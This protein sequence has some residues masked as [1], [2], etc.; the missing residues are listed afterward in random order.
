[1]SLEVLDLVSSDKIPIPYSQEISKR[2]DPKKTSLFGK[3]FKNKKLGKPKTVAVIYLRNNGLAE[4][5][6]VQVKQGFFGIYGKTYHERRDCTYV[7]TKN[8][9]PLA[10]IMEDEILPIGLKSWNDKDLREKC[11]ALQEHVM[12]GI[13]HAER[14]RMGDK[15]QNNFDV[16]KIL[17]FLIVAG[18]AIAVLTSL[19]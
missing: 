9:F 12:S 7:A 16:K 2:E 18:I 3:L 4:F 14:V 10:L 6:E 17:G 5:M 19:L 11:L 8:R 15:G 1:M 13:R